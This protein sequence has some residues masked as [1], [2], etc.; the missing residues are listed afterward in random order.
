MTSYLISDPGRPW[1][2][3]FISPKLDAVAEAIVA[4]ERLE[5]STIYATLDGKP[6][7]LSAEEQIK[8]YERVLE[9]KPDDQQA[10]TELASARQRLSDK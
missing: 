7:S 9:L 3:L 6:R 5:P 4:Q 2:A 10:A 1:L 8:L